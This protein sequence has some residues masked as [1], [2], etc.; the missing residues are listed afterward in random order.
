MNVPQMPRSRF[1]LSAK[2]TMILPGLVRYELD[3]DQIGM[4]TE[5]PE[6]AFYLPS[7]SKNSGFRIREALAMR[8]KGR[9]VERLQ[10][11]NG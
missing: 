10:K 8:C 11:H 7:H 6:E 4:L 2:Q 9:D 5:V 3:L 1:G